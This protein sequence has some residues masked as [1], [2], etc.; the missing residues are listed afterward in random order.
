MVA[1][2]R[3]DDVDA[4]GQL[5]ELQALIVDVDGDR[6]QRV[7]FED[8]AQ[9]GIA[10]IF[11]GGGAALVEQHLRAEPQRILRAQRDQ[12]LFRT[13][14]DAA[15]RQR[16]LRDE[17]DQLRVV[18]LVIVGRDGGKFLLAERLQRAEPPVVMVE[19]RLVGLAVDEAVRIAAPVRRLFR[20]HLAAE[21]LADGA[22][23]VDGRSVVATAGIEPL[24]SRRAV[25]NEIARAVLRPQIV[26]G[27]QLAIGE[28]HGDPADAQM[29]RQL[30]ARGQLVA[31]AEAA[32]QNAFRDQVLDLLLQR[33]FE[34]RIEKRTPQAEWACCAAPALNTCRVF[35]SRN[36]RSL[37]TAESGNSKRRRHRTGAAAKLPEITRLNRTSA[38]RVRP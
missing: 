17:L 14:E 28:R 8:R 24:A 34:F 6:L 33:A 23:P 35:H 3:E 20:Q 30:A 32:R 1:R 37:T 11:H 10:G 38:C 7:W 12:D 9:S 26:V 15:P 2:R 16:M 25:G 27:Q 21:P 13:G 29:M 5:L 4:A 31:R 22:V 19:Q 36:R 18:A